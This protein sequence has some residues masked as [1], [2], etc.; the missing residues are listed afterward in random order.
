M[1]A[2]WVLA[3]FV[4][5][6]SDKNYDT[7]VMLLTSDDAMRVH[8]RLLELHYRKNSFRFEDCEFT[9]GELDYVTFTSI[10][11]SGGIAVKL[12]ASTIDS[13][14]RLI[15]VGDK[16]RVAAFEDYTLHNVVDYFG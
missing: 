5:C 13:S 10:G 3:V 11:G 14:Y 16:E 9:D 6:T 2:L 15:A 12:T 1:D 8:S 7:F 4:M